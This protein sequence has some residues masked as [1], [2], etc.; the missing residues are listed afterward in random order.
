LDSIDTIITHITN[1]KI[2]S[3]NIG[4]IEDEKIRDIQSLKSLVFSRELLTPL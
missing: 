3:K 4:S 1:N 2:N